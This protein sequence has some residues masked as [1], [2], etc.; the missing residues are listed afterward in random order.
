MP[1]QT[2][3]IVNG[4]FDQ[5]S[6]GWTGTDIE[7]TYTETAYLGNG[8]TNRVAELDGRVGQTTAMVQTISIAGPITTE[9]TFD[10][11]LRTQNVTVGSDGFKVEIRDATGTVIAEMT[12]LPPT[13]GTYATYTLPVEF[14]AQ[15]TYTIHFIERGPD[16]SYGAIID[17][18]EMMVCFAGQTLIDTPEGPRPAIDIRVGDLVVT[19]RG[20]LPVRW[21]GRRGV[22]AAQ[23]AGDDKYR[24]V[25]ISA[26]ALG[27]GL[28]RADLWV[29]RQ[30][31]MLISSP[32]CRRMFGHGE[33][34]VAAVRLTALP[35]IYIDQ[36]ITR[37]DY[38]HLLFDQHEVIFAEGAPSES[39]LLH[40][41]ALAALTP[42]ARDELRLM[43]PDRFTAAGMVQN[44]KLIPK[45]RQQARLADRLS[46]NGRSAL[47]SFQAAD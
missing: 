15:G 1:P 34:L 38:V 27:Q 43:F 44:A 13:I 21:V 23:M 35:G 18:I 6:V 41:E 37:I 32:V 28:P 22:T 12:V 10:A 40:N 7:T 26:G 20:P 31:R 17:N 5:Q 46:R 19:E 39:L 33:T 45:G 47:E 36:E 25:K 24:P 9:L 2:N 16:N 3:I 14:P 11:T 30:H 29:S 42:E 4:T 8:S